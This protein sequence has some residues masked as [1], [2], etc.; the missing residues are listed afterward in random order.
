MDVLNV[1][2]LIGAIASVVGAIVAFNQKKHAEDARKATEA[3]RDATFAAK[4]KFFQNIQ[5]EDFAKFKKEC[6]KFCETLRLAGSRKQ[7]QGRKKNYLESELEKFVTKLNDAISNASGENRTKLEKYYRKLQNDR[8]KV[9]SDKTET[10]KD[11]LDDV[12]E[13]SR[14]I[15]D[16]QMNN[17]LSL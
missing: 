13:L 6:D 15:A 2:S 5:Y 10:I 1:I 14:L 3:A 9:H 16:I 4:E 8:P 12:R 11:V 17:K 7:V